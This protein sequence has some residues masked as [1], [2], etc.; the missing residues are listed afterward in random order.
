MGGEV[1]NKGQGLERE[2]LNRFEIG[3][4]A[5]G[6]SFR[7]RIGYSG[8]GLVPASAFFFIPVLDWLD[9]GQSGIPAFSKT[10]RRRKGVHV[11]EY[12]ADDGIKK[13]GQIVFNYLFVKENF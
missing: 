2:G 10:V 6:S 11:Y 4:P 7:Y 1:G 5:S 13:Q 12:T 8:T 9:A 3:V